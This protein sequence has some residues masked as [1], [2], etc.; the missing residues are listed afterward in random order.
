MEPAGIENVPE[1][2]KCIICRNDVCKQCTACETEE[3]TVRL[4]CTHLFH[5]GC[6]DEWFDSQPDLSCPI[7]RHEI[8]GEMCRISP[9]DL[10]AQDDPEC[11]ICFDLFFQSRCQKHVQNK[12]CDHGKDYHRCCIDKWLK[13]RQC[14]PMDNRAWLEGSASE[15]EQRLIEIARSDELFVRAVTDFDVTEEDWAF[16]RKCK[17]TRITARRAAFDALRERFLTPNYSDE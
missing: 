16:I 17:F 9:G 6:L 12:L 1:I 4:K 11:S 3:S 13:T 10:S 8:D 2:R 14:C 7:C 5:T 15:H